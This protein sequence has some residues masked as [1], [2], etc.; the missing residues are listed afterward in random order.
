MDKYKLVGTHARDLGS[1][2]MLAVG[3]TVD[4]TQE[5]AADSHNKVLIDE[6]ILIPVPSE[7][8]EEPPKKKST[9]E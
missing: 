9:K 2:A 3:E 7:T 1:G 8:E 4:F 6:G 5:Q